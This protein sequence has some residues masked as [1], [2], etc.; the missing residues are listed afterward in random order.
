MQMIE[1]FVFTEIESM[2]FFR[3]FLGES[4]FCLLTNLINEFFVECAT[5]NTFVLL[6]EKN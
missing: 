4:F 2:P 5:V 1:N 3:M 6:E